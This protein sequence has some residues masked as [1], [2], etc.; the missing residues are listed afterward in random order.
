ADARIVLMDEPTSRLPRESVAR[1]FEAIGRLRR[2]GLAVLYVSHFL[3]EVREIAD[4]FT[5]LRDGRSVASGALSEV[6]DGQLVEKM[7]GRAAA[8]L[9]AS[10]DADRTREPLE[11][12]LEAEDLALPPRLVSASLSLRGGEILG[13]AGLVGSG[14]TD[15]VR[16]LFGLERPSAGRIRLRGRELPIGALS[17]GA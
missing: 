3:E 12:I 8:P 13:I 5:V 17:S 2:R 11:V 10:R 7:L 4:R 14:R 9:L 16:C 6:T 1:L 15:L